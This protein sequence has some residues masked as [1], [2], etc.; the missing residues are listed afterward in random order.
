MFHT[1]T[2]EAGLWCQPGYAHNVDPSSDA[3]LQDPSGQPRTLWKPDWLNANTPT[4]Y[5]TCSG[6]H[7]TSLPPYSIAGILPGE[8]AA[9]S[10]ALKQGGTRTSLNTHVLAHTLL[11]GSNEPN[12]AGRTVVRL[13]EK[14]TQPCQGLETLVSRPGIGLSFNSDAA[15]VYPP[16]QEHWRSTHF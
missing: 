4:D 10:Y 11:S 16:L 3:S 2:P 7:D 12:M 5:Y 14:M 9:P 15:A 1:E 6:R 13:F 8:T